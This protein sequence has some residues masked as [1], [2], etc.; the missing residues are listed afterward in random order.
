M[1]CTAESMTGVVH[2]GALPATML[3]VHPRDV[4]AF[5]LAALEPCL[6]PPAYLS[7]AGR[8]SSRVSCSSRHLQ[9]PLEFMEF[10]RP[11][12]GRCYIM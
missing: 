5:L 3:Q 10:I 6:L 8:T 4:A 2:R 9:L 12:K 7:Y 11:T 1:L